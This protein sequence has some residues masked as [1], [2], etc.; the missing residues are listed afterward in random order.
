[1]VV[2]ENLQL[3]LQ[4]CLLVA[5]VVRVQPEELVLMLVVLEVQEQM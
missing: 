1:M 4:R 5:V 2:M 3:L